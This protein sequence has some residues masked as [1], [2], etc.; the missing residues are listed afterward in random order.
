MEYKSIVEVNK[1]LWAEPPN[2]WIRIAFAGACSAR[3]P[4]LGGSGPFRDNSR[5]T[6]DWFTPMRSAI[7]ACVASLALSALMRHLYLVGELA[8]R[9]GHSP[10]A[11]GA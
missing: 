7:S 11:V 8:V 2:P 1:P 4:Q 9:Q 3:Q 5:L 10:L 6:V